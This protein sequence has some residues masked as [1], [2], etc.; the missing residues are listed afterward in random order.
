[1][2]LRISIL[3]HHELL[4]LETHAYKRVLFG[5]SVLRSKL[6]SELINWCIEPKRDVLDHFS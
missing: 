3:D 2:H 6:L 1:M 5:E 4:S